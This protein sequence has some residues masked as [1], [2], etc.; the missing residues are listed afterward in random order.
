MVTL[1]GTVVT[2]LTGCSSKQAATLQ[3]INDM[4]TERHRMKGCV[5]VFP[6][7]TTLWLTLL[8]NFMITMVKC[9]TFFFSFFNLCRTLE[10]THGVRIDGVKK[11]KSFVIDFDFPG[12]R[13]WNLFNV[14]CYLHC[15][16]VCAVAHY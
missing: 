3:H 6:N 7:N 5:I 8:D 16:S 13:Q 12:E 11:K 2:P 10:S 15:P 14:L 4:S 9:C 1:Y